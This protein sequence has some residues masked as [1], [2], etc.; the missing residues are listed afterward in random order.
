[1]RVADEQ[2]EHKGLL[3]IVFNDFETL[4]KECFIKRLSYYDCDWLFSDYM[5]RNRYHMYFKDLELLDSVDCQPNVH[6]SNEE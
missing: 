6:Y 3:Y 1:M 4:N 5:I 2:H